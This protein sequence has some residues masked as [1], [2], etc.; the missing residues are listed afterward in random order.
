MS[1][2]LPQDGGVETNGGMRGEPPDFEA[3]AGCGFRHCRH[4][5]VAVAKFGQNMQLDY[6]LASVHF[7][8]TQDGV[9]LDCD[10]RFE[11]FSRYLKEDYKNDLRYVVEKYFEN[12]I[13]MMF[14][15]LSHH[16]NAGKKRFLSAY[17][18]VLISTITP[19]DDA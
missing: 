1:G 12:V 14:L 4:G 8:P 10:G 5:G 19:A 15:I 2:P 6:R 18:L 16:L 13:R 7:V 9:W 11:R 17:D 3:I